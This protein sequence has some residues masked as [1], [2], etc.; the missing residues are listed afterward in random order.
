[1]Q[2]CSSSAL[3]PSSESLARRKEFGKL[4]SALRRVRSRTPF[5][6]LAAHRI[7][8][9]WGLYRGLR[10]EAPT[11][12]IRWRMRKIFEKNRG[13]T[14]SEK[15][16]ICLRRGYKWLETFQRTR[17]GDTHLQAVL[18]RYSRMIA[19]KREREHWEQ[20]LGEEWAWQE[21][22][23]KKPILTGSLLRASL[24]NPPLP[25]LYPLPEHISRM[26]HKRRVAREARFAKQ[27][28]LLEQ[29]QDLIREAQFEEGALTGNSAKLVFG[30]ENKNEWTK[31]VRDG[32]T[33]IVQAYERSQARLRTTVSPELFEVMAAARRFKI[34]NKTRERENERRGVLTRASLKR[35]RGRP[36]AHVWDR[37][38]EEEKEVDRV[39][40]LQGEGGYVGMVKRMAGMRMRDGDTWKK[41][42][43]ANEEAKERECQVERENERRRVE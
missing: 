15:T 14:G 40:R 38:S 4:F 8:T 34:A 33:E 17:S 13:L 2:K 26:I 6:E 12:D 21:R 22:M 5:F 24:D 29:Q 28:V 11:S 27:Q 36:P 41:E 23:R 19:A 31:E 32:L 18:E 25:R 1:M 37:M 42:V 43:E 39:K 10:R 35:A 9:L 3:E 20:V 7:P 16:I 30:G